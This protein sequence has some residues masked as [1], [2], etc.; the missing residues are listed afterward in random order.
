MTSLN[1][2]LSLIEKIL[3]GLKLD[4]MT[5]CSIGVTKSVNL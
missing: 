2:T 4:F 5:H 1:V 3:V